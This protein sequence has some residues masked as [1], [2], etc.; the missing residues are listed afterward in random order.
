MLNK[1][2]NQSYFL[3][4]FPSLVSFFVSSYFLS[5]FLEEDALVRH[6]WESKVLPVRAV[7]VYSESVVKL[8][9]FFSLALDV[10]PGTR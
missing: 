10:A 3:P 6:V 4:F 8:H 5:F 1:I 7:N 9:S 2:L